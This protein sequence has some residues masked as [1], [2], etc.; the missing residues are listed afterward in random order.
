MVKCI[1]GCDIRAK[2][3]FESPLIVLLLLLLLLVGHRRHSE[4]EHELVVR[5]RRQSGGQKTEIGHS[6]QRTGSDVHD[7]VPQH[8]I[9]GT[10][11]YNERD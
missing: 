10:S 5:R 11:E 2:N 7:S 3:K 9:R 6:A 4:N 8:R 1:N